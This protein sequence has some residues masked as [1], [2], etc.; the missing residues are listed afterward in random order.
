[1]VGWWLFATLVIATM[2][3]DVVKEKDYF[4]S[5]M[6]HVRD[7]T[8]S[9]LEF[10][11]V[12]VLLIITVVTEFCLSLISFT[13]CPFNVLP[14]DVI[15]LIIYDGLF[16]IQHY[17]EEGAE[18]VF[19]FNDQSASNDIIQSLQCLDSRFYTVYDSS[20]FSGSDDAESVPFQKMYSSLRNLSEWLL[21]VNSGE[22]ITSRAAPER[23]IKDI[24]VRYLS[25][26][27]IISI[28]ELTFLWSN[29]T[30]AV[31]PGN[32]RYTLKYRHGLDRKY[33]ANAQHVPTTYQT[34]SNKILVQTS[35]VSVF[36]QGSVGFF[37]GDD[38]GTVCIPR[39]VGTMSCAANLPPHAAQSYAAVKQSPDKNLGSYTAL[40]QLG[41]YE[42]P[43]WCPFATSFR[44]SQSP[45]QT[46]MLEE[47]IENMQLIAFY[48]PT[49]SVSTVDDSERLNRQLRSSS[50]RSHKHQHH[51][52]AQD[53]SRLAIFDDFITSIR[54][55][56][57]LHQSLFIKT[58]ELFR[59]CPG[60]MDHIPAAVPSIPDGSLQFSHH[61]ERT[62]G[63][64]VQH[65][66]E[67]EYFLAAMV[68][69]PYD[70]NGPNSP[71][72]EFEY[73]IIEFMQ[74]S[75]EEGFDHVFFFFMDEGGG[76]GTSPAADEVERPAHR[77]LGCV[78][79]HFYTA[80]N[81]SHLV[82]N[83]ERI[84]T[85]EDA[86]SAMYTDL[87]V[88]ARS[89]WLAVLEIDDFITSRAYPQ[90][91]VREVLT[92]HLSLCNMVSVP[93]NSFVWGTQDGNPR[94]NV[95]YSLFFRVG[96][97]Q[98]YSVSA[99]DA[100][101]KPPP[102]QPEPI[103][104]SKNA[105]KRK[106]EGEENDDDEEGREVDQRWQGESNVLIFRAD[107]VPDFRSVQTARFGLA[108]YMCI[109][110]T[111][112]QMKCAAQLRHI[113]RTTATSERSESSDSNWGGGKE[114]QQAEAA[115]ELDFQAFDAVPQQ[116]QSRYYLDVYNRSQG[117]P[118]FCP[119]RNQFRAMG[120]AART[121]LTESDIDKLQLASFRY[122]V[123]SQQ[124][125]DAT[126]AATSAMNQHQHMDSSDG[127]PLA[128]NA[129]IYDDFMHSV[130][131]KARSNHPFFLRADSTVGRCP[132]RYFDAAATLPYPHKAVPEPPRANSVRKFQQDV[133]TPKHF[134]SVMV[135]V[136]DEIDS[137]IEF[138]QVSGLICT[139]GFHL[140][141]PS[142]FIFKILQFCAF[143]S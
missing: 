137:I 132:A 111:E 72:E 128:T 119:F 47:D 14:T 56:K 62:G 73:S 124:M 28:P 30:A 121:Y 69:I 71:D 45:S 101:P 109:P 123:R 92:D 2:G 103:K 96:Y 135:I 140:I 40:N 18:H 24:L 98:A 82:I 67:R 97:G 99:S 63:R 127:M 27:S 114:A 86:L 81:R 1:M 116:P 125:W 26:C 76:G 65:L 142:L 80:Y 83:P 113:T 57:R 41:S 5:V 118:Q 55:Q 138:M 15:T 6:V 107:N 129:D 74:H 22:F 8:Y 43:K 91:S 59:T 104:P 7:E 19:I 87:G 108:A 29:R 133:G 25:H 78:D 93:L 38:G 42:L 32:V 35:R 122:R 9:I 31:P 131:R 11:Q 34:S 117:L 54:R 84:L 3:M 139:Y 48:F 106:V 33:E 79:A 75:I 70:G 141:H 115:A 134:L 36:K 60:Y 120:P 46:L 100:L 44:S 51:S 85:P 77:A 64:G 58:A 95:R 23:N 53:A 10:T 12:L 17:L 16:L 68:V 112:P 143:S 136:K 21:V 126:S 94:N 88:K 105:A 50:G 90:L 102:G 130:R 20:Y 37:E 49:V 4:F 52:H 39:S 61:L 110:H 66:S 13:L 89:E